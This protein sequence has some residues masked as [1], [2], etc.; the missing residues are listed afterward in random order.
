LYNII[1]Y[2]GII[3]YVSFASRRRRWWTNDNDIQRK[4]T[5]TDTQQV[6]IIII[7]YLY[8]RI[9]YITRIYRGVNKMWLVHSWS[10]MRGINPFIRP[11]TFC[12]PS[13][14][15]LAQSLVRLQQRIL[16]ECCTILHFAYILHKLRNIVL[17][18]IFL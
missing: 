7:Y 6:A 16:P 18:G 8:T 14:H 9:I 4:R 15:N 5:K 13:A 1:M 10:S 2:H 17:E 11:N 12:L 3:F